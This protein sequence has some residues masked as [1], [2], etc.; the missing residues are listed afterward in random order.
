MKLK[1]DNSMM[2]LHVQVKY[3]L[4]KISPDILHLSA[5]NI[6]SNHGHI[7]HAHYAGIYNVPQV[8]LKD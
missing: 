8:P 5:A 7:F 1:G 3:D 4:D 2:E 6:E